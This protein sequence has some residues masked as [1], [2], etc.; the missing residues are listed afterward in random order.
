MGGSVS[1]QDV[2]STN[3]V[4]ISAIDTDPKRAADIANAVSEAMVNYNA[5]EQEMSAL[6]SLKFLNQQLEEARDRLTQAEAKLFEY[7][8][9]NQIFE[10]QV[11]KDQ[12]AAQR[13]KLSADQIQI[14]MDIAMYDAR[15][16]AFK[17]L[18]AK[19]DYDKF[20]SPSIYGIGNE[21]ETTP[22]GGENR[23]VAGQG[24]DPVLMGLSQNLVS[25][26][27][28]YNML[29]QKYKEQHP[30]VVEAKNKIDVLKAQFEE[31][32]KKKIT[33]LELEKS[34]LV[35]KRDKVAQDIDM[36]NKKAVDITSKDAEYVVLERETNSARDLFNSL[37]VA[38][39]EANIAGQWLLQ[40][41]YLYP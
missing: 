5:L 18:L 39:K 33:G 41:P 12:L 21:F 36:E 17:T 32:L 22:S 35:A 11:D 31:E 7:K 20:V 6:N 29:T 19:K 38:V 30:E 15:I 14:E 40:G 24:Q 9:N 4:Y 25:A 10:T 23:F 27:I 26:E 8:T 2:E 37:L 34:I 3:L 28:E 13:G 16:N 1:Y